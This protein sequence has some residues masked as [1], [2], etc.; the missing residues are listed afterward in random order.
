MQRLY[1][2]ILDHPYEV[3]QYYFLPISLIVVS[4]HR[5]KYFH[6]V[7]SS[8]KQVHQ[9]AIK[10]FAPYIK[11][12]ATTLEKT[13]ATINNIVTTAKCW[14]RH[15]MQFLWCL[16]H[17]SIQILFINLVIL[18]K[19][20]WIAMP[21]LFHSDF[22]HMYLYP[23]SEWRNLPCYIDYKKIPTLQEKVT[24]KCVDQCKV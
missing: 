1:R 9:F 2:F 15:Y 16:S 24:Q 20:Y 7:H 5:F 21:R 22:G 8:N 18:N 4:F 14:G 23:K 3:L 13:Q 10:I 6:I 11:N 17:A 19:L 12:I